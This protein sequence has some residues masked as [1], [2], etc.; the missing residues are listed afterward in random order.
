M[1]CLT[2]EEIV[3]RKSSDEAKDRVD[4]NIR[5]PATWFT[6]SAANSSC[7]T[8]RHPC[9]VNASQL[10]LRRR[11]SKSAGAS[12]TK[13]LQ[14]AA[15]TSEQ[16]IQMDDKRWE[17]YVVAAEAYSGQQLYDDAIGMLQ[18]A[19]VRA[20]ADKKPAVRDAITETRKMLAGPT[21]TA[22][23]SVP[24]APAAPAG[25]GQSPTPAATAAS[26]GAAP[27]QAEIIL[28][29]SIENSKSASD[30]QAYLDAYPN[31][32][33]APLASRRFQDLRE[34]TIDAR[35][36]QDRIKELLQWVQQNGFHGAAPWGATLDITTV[37]G[38]RITVV[39]TSS[40]VTK[41]GVVTQSSST[42]ES[43]DLGT[44]V[45]S[46]MQILPQDNLWSVNVP[47]GNGFNQIYFGDRAVAAEAF[48]KLVEAT[49]LCH[50]SSSA[51]RPSVRIGSQ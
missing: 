4:F 16:A 19:L 38:C 30:Y 23:P 15:T 34:T 50:E 42:I 26:P 44:A 27:T 6:S 8:R 9:T 48:D 3:E 11:C 33:Y 51:A 20:P 31:G 12:R 21:A 47:G 17:G 40:S 46:N 2:S 25:S 18:M 32:V 39:A 24:S 49:N 1:S 43:I 35:K 36:Q 37:N 28:W 13:R 29:K 10:G 41:K 45:G 14:D 7:P 5:L 22:A